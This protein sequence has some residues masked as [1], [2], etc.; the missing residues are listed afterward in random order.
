M[1][2]LA[3]VAI[4]GAMFWAVT[5]LACWLYNLAAKVTGGVE[6]ELEMAP[7]IQSWQPAPDVAASAS[8]PESRSP[9]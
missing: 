8:G 3:G 7:S 5:A 9:G 4:Y 2:G 6:L 1:A